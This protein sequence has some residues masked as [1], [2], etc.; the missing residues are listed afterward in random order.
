MSKNKFTKLILFKENE[1]EAM[2]KYLEEKA[3]EGW[4]LDDISCGFFTF[5]RDEPKKCK[6]TVDIFE[7]LRAG[8]YRQYCESV[9]WN[10]VAETSKY[11]VFY[12][13]NEDITPI[14]TDEELV[15]Q[16]VGKSMLGNIF[17]YILALYFIIPPVYH[18]FFNNEYGNDI[19][20]NY[21]LF[22]ILISIIFVICPIL[23]IVRTSLWYVKFKKAMKSEEEV[24]YPSLKE[25]KIGINIFNL[26]ISIFL[27]VI[28]CLI[29]GLGEKE[30]YLYT[31]LVIMSIIV[32]GIKII[33][34]I[35]A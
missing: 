30:A 34:I 20:G 14:Q 31:G 24:T 33:K 15:L 10:Y 28:L 29:V 25:L 22:I 7:Q 19:Y 13:E 16:K 21:Y 1:C 11:F 2:E 5:K 12:T 27:V 17:F 4:F 8:E 3:L 18:M 26:Y 32:Y 9:G 6:F 23:N 35:T